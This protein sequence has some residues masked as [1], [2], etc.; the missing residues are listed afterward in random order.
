MSKKRDLDVHGRPEQGTDEVR[1]SA[2]PSESRDS[3]PPLM[4]GPH[5]AGQPLRASARPIGNEGAV[6]ILVATEWSDERARAANAVDGLGVSLEYAVTGRSALAKLRIDQFDVLLLD[7]TLPDMSAHEV[8]ETIAREVLNTKIIVLA[9]DAH[10]DDAKRALRGGANDFVK[11]WSEREVLRRAVTEALGERERERRQSKQER[12]L[13]DSEELHRFMVNASPE[14]VYMLDQ[15]GKFTFL[16]DRIVSLLGFP[17]DE[18]IGKHYTD[19]VHHDDRE[20]ARF[21]FDERRTGARS[22]R[23]VELR[24]NSLRGGRRHLDTAAV[25]VE[26]TSTGLYSDVSHRSSEYFL[27]TFG[28]ARDV[29]ERKRADEVINFQA[30][31]DLLTQLPNRALLKDRLSVA[32]THAERNQRRLALMFLDLNRFKLVNDS[33]GHS[34][35][36]QLLKSVARRLQGVI[37]KGDTVARFGGDEFTLLLPEVRTHEDVAAIARKILDILTQPFLIDGHELYVGVS[38]GIA[39]YP[40]A[41]DTAESLIQNADIAMYNIKGRGQNGYQFFSQEMN[42]RFSTR[43]SMERELRVALGSEQLRVHYQP[44]VRM[45]DGTIAG[46]EAM[47]RWQHPRL[48]LIEPADFL[49]IADDAGLMLTLDAWVQGTACRELKRWSEQGYDQLNLAINVTAGQLEQE[50][51]LERFLATVEGAGLGPE[52]IRI[53]LKESTI[54]KD[55][56]QVIPRLQALSQ[57]GVGIAID[58][59]G[60]GYGS[61]ALLQRLPIDVIKIDRAFLSDFHNDEAANRVID[62]IIG[63]GTALGVTLVAEGVESARQLRYLQHKGLEEVQGYYFSRAV[64][65]ED[66]CDL[67]ERGRL[68]LAA[69]PDETVELD[70]EREAEH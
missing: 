70:P 68:P 4:P 6:R 23:N 62:A 16:N 21:A 61:I 50:D 14:L 69:P 11:G 34:M 58:D 66:I 13:R 49:S 52:R 55:I 7:L 39:L 59:F 24:L 22:S 31:H 25:F 40:D 60:T 32:V 53:E 2:A 17:R 67:L 48:G 45:H 19:L 56:E 8:I 12:T 41:G 30:Y 57:L 64:P 35:G 18:L 3:Y 36:D 5:A 33:L 10:F 44:L 65:A 46:V 27:G 26:L 47:V 29:T 28:T 43:V 54:T 1:S 9:E 15:E 63:M 42:E 37:R 20:I 51:F 38:I